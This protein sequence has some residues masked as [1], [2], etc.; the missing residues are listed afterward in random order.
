MSTVILHFAAL[1]HLP[2]QSGNHTLN[3]AEV[4][5]LTVPQKLEKLCLLYECQLK[6][7]TPGCFERA[8]MNLHCIQ[9][10]IVCAVADCP[11]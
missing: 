2:E 6:H 11:R 8:Q 4:V 1:S 7:V 10:Q 5:I 3:N 9:N